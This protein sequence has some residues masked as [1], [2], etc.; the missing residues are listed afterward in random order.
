MLDGEWTLCPECAR[1]TAQAVEGLPVEVQ[2]VGAGQAPANKG[3]RKAGLGLGITSAVLAFVGFFL[4]YFG[5]LYMLVLAITLEESI[6]DPTLMIVEAEVFSASMGGLLVAGIG[7]FCAIPA[8][9]VGI[10]SIV[11]AVKQKGRGQVLP[12]PALV[13]GI[14]ACVLTALA[15]LLFLMCGLM[16]IG[17]LDTYTLIY[18]V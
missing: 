5:V 15:L 2:V 4:A 8:L 6:Y 16:V 11:R 1:E 14:A 17:V 3:S 18:T 10:V 13:L 12:I 9:V 7:A